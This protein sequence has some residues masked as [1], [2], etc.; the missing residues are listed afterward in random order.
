[1]C[2]NQRCIFFTKEAWA[3]T[4]FKSHNTYGQKM[5]I[6]DTRERCP[7]YPFCRSVASLVFRCLLATKPF[8]SFSTNSW[9]SSAKNQLCFRLTPV[10]WYAS[11]HSS[12]D[13]GHDAKTLTRF[14][15]FTG[16]NKIPFWWWAKW[17]WGW[18]HLRQRTK[19]FWSSWLFYWLKLQT[20][21]VNVDGLWHDCSLSL[22]SDSPNVITMLLKIWP[23]RHH[24]PIN[25]HQLPFCTLPG[26]SVQGRSTQHPGGPV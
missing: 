23:H 17:F 16:A 21:V 1:M 20:G 8:K 24:G 19:L 25:H 12:R 10:H 13:Q 5:S 7:A 26:F 4:T 14:L 6:F 22:S 3:Q 11:L 18:T 9:W 15:K 2:L